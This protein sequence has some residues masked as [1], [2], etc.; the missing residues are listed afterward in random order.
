MTCKAEPLYRI[1]TDDWQCPKC[2]A[3]VR[4]PTEHVG[5]LSPEMKDGGKP[6]LETSDGSPKEPISP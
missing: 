5:K 6:Q 2:L 3:V 1:A 4:H